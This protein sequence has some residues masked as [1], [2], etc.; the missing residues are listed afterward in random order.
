VDRTRKPKPEKLTNSVYSGS[1]S[2][3]V[4][5]FKMASPTS[6]RRPSPRARHHGG[7]GGTRATAGTGGDDGNVGRR[8]GRRGRES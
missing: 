7:A 6:G 2:G 4:H 3:S 5:G 8:Q 1:G